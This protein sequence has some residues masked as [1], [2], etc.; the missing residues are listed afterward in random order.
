MENFYHELG[1][2]PTATSD[3]IKEAYSRLRAKLIASGMEEVELSLKTTELEKAYST[4]SDANERASYDRSLGAQA[5]SSSTTA[6]SVLE[7]PA[8]ILRSEIPAPQVQQP[9]PYC[10]A[11]NPIQASMCVQCG[12]Q[13]T[14]PCPNCGQAV[15]LTQS[16]CSR[17]NTFLPEYD[18][19]RLAQAIIVEQKTQNE[20]LTSESKVQALEAGHRARGVRGVFFWFL[21]GFACIVLTVTPILIFN[22]VMNNP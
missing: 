2:L 13:I 17:C 4:L 11:P 10:G 21:V 22:Y 18:Q 3:E 19:R 6:L 5:H 20:R 16:V 1:L 15:L 7:R 8:T 14:R 12:Q 9:C